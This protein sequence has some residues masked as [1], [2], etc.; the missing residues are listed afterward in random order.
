MV[1]IGHTKGFYSGKYNETQTSSVKTVDACKAACLA[2]AACVQITWAVRPKDPCV[3]YQQ[4]NSKM[5]IIKG[6]VGFV[7]CGAGATDPSACAAITPVPGAPQ[8]VL[9]TSID[10]TQKPNVLAG[11]QNWLVLGRTVP[12]IETEQELAEQELL[13]AGDLD[14]AAAAPI[15]TTGTT[16][17]AM[18]HMVTGFPFTND[19]SIRIAPTASAPSSTSLP[20]ALHL[21]MP[22]WVPSLVDVQ[23]NGQ[24]HPTAGTPGSYL[25]ISG[26]WKVGDVISISLPTVYGFGAYSGDDQIKG[27][28]GK[29]YALSVGPVVLAL[30][31]SMTATSA[32]PWTSILPHPPSSANIS[33]WLIPKP[34]QSGSSGSSLH[35]TV[36]GAPGFEF[37]PMWDVPE[38]QAFTTYP[39]FSP[40]SAHQAPKKLRGSRAERRKYL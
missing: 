38:G 10:M 34:A 32:T 30:V 13:L 21:R 16:V 37:M 14:V 7:K 29:R 11:V 35:F 28:E 31:G 36:A 3:M 4:I 6:A 40:L 18:L 17:E 25:T 12:N 1:A 19:I 2:D 20:F 39:I 9:Y 23:I 24:V 22:S 15:S 26:P 33:S 5:Q 8:C 27:Y